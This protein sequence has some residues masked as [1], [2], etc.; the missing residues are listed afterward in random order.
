MTPILSSLSSHTGVEVEGVDLRE[1]LPAGLRDALYAAF[2]ERSVLVV[3]GQDLDPHQMLA[4]AKQFGAPFEQHNTRFQLPE[5]P[6]IHYISNQDKH[7]D[8]SRYIPGSGYHTDHS[9]SASPPKATLLHA[10]ELPSSGGDTQFVN[11][12]VAYLD[13]D[14]ATRGLID[15]LQ[16]EHV[17]QSSHSAR[18]LVGLTDKRRQEV[19]QSVLH[20]LVRPHTETG[21]PALYIN[22]IRIERIV[23]MD[24]ETALP[25][26]DR[27]LAHAI[28][29]E[30]QYRHRWRP[31]DF[32]MWDNRRLLHKANGDYD[33]S[34]RRYLYR[35]MLQDGPP[36]AMA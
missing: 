33:M 4:A 18:K 10:K 7:A 35:L 12:R 9:N 16:A 15:G 6:E 30:R 1:P 24:D 21:E 26:L 31:G 3:R 36:P 11:M 23:G 22:P 19:E 28:E 8:G 14:D 2:L 25:L 32:V 27:L 20:P 29:P 34:E 17:Y 5:C 13:L